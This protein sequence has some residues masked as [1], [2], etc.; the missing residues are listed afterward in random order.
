[1]GCASLLFVQDRERLGYIFVS[2]AS[3]TLVHFC[4]VA[5]PVPSLNSCRIIVFDFVLLE[6]SGL[7][8]SKLMD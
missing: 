7:K 1:M 4:S 3:E 2:R 5:I 8:E 6:A